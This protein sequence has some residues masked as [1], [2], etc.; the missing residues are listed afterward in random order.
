[1]KWLFSFFKLRASFFTPP[2]YTRPMLFLL[3]RLKEAQLAELE[4]TCIELMGVCRRMGEALVEYQS[5]VTTLEQI[6]E[7]CLSKLEEIKRLEAENTWLQQRLTEKMQ[8]TRNQSDL[9]DEL[10]QGLIESVQQSEHEKRDQS[11]EH[12]IQT[13]EKRLMQKLP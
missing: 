11:Y 3:Y 1:M 2:L 4:Q 9:I 7:E 5:D 8:L 10:K 12:R 6:Q 13:L